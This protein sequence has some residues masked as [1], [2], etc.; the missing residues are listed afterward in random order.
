M[1]NAIE[2]PFIMRN[3][4]AIIVSKVAQSLRTVSFRFMVEQKYIYV[5]GIYVCFHSVGARHVVNT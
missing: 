5:N 1:L 4:T 3:A 2:Q